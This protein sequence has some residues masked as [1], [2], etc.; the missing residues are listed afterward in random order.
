MKTKTIVPT[1]LITSV[2]I[3]IYQLIHQKLTERRE[4]ASQRAKAMRIISEEEIKLQEVKIILYEKGKQKILDNHSLYFPDVLYECI[5]LLITADDGYKLYV[6]EEMIG[7]IK[8]EGVALEIIYPEAVNIPVWGVTYPIT[9]LLIPLKGK[10][11]M[12]SEAVIFFLI[13]E[14]SKNR[15]YYGN[16]INRQGINNLKKILKRWR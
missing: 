16:A 5:R 11:P 14:G 10:Y 1:I 4:L 2:G 8:K 9:K 12:N 15:P 6:T 3:L 7:E 13:K